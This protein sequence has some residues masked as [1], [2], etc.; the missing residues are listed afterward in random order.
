MFAGW[1]D[2]LVQGVRVGKDLVITPSGIVKAVGVLVIG[3]GLVNL[4][5]R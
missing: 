3:M 2:A 5:Q 4:F 1:T